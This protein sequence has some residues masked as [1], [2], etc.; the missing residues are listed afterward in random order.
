MHSQQNM[1]GC[2]EG[3]DNLHPKC[4]SAA[5]HESSSKLH[6]VPLHLQL[7]QQQQCT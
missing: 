2:T 5:A 7:W 1:L 4:S 3:C 6:M